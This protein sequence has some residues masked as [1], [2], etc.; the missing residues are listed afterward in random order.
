MTAHVSPGSSP[1]S[2]RAVRLRL[3]HD[4]DA[5]PFADEVATALRAFARAV[6]PD[7]PDF[8]HLVGQPTAPVIPVH[9]SGSPGSRPD[10]GGAEG[11]GDA[12]IRAGARRRHPSV[13]RSLVAAAAVAAV[14]AGAVLLDRVPGGTPD[15]QVGISVAAPTDGAFDAA[16]AP[17]VWVSDAADP[18]AAARS[19]LEAA[20]IPAAVVPAA[21]VPGAGAPSEAVPPAPVPGTPPPPGL[22]AAPEVAPPSSGAPELVLR[23]LADRIAVVGWSGGDGPRGSTGTVILRRSPGAEGVWSVV[24]SA[25]DAVK[26]DDV[27][28]DGEHLSFTVTRTSHVDA[29]VAVGVWADD[30]PIGLGDEATAAGSPDQAGATDPAGVT[31]DAI[32]R[33]VEIGAGPGASRAITVTFDR[34]ETARVRV[35]HLVGGQPASVT[36]MVVAL[37][38][39]GRG[40]E[41]AG[42]TG[43]VPESRRGGGAGSDVPAGASPDE[44]VPRSSIPSA[45][46]PGLPLLGDEVESLGEPLPDL[47]GDG[48]LLEDGGT[49]PPSLTLPTLPPLELP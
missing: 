15:E 9:R 34:A 7:R 41:P 33:I 12:G 29:P 1:G 46:E 37:T 49:T 17:V 6:D 31:G 8:D 13:R 44:P 23:E 45:P 39:S 18:V 35:H 16:T 42:S 40:A 22:P 27:R 38:G 14:V 19:Y 24:G 32:G 43:D 4:T 20:G 2:P 5:D 3:V 36:E 47:P 21:V 25:S 11:S 48:T 30:R 10:P 28:Y 26:L